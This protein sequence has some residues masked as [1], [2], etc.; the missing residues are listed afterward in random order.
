[1]TYDKQE[2][3]SLLQVKGK[4]II[5]DSGT[6]FF[7]MPVVDRMNLVHDISMKAKTQCSQ[8][9]LPICYCGNFNFPHLDLKIEDQTYRIPKNS[10]VKRVKNAWGDEVCML[11]IMANPHIGFYIM[12]LNFFENYYTVFDKER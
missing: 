12:G 2:T 3:N 10:Y 7:L 1:M 6:S 11:K 8:N 4:K 5:V 9:R